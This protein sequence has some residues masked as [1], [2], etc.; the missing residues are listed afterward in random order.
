MTSQASP[1]P[2]HHPQQPH[3]IP[4]NIDVLTPPV[5]QPTQ[6]P[7]TLPPPAA[8]ESA[9][10]TCHTRA[11]P[12]RSTEYH[13]RAYD[14]PSTKDL[15][16][17][18]H[19]TIGSPVKST[20]LHAVQCGNFRSF[21]GLSPENVARYCPTNATPTLLGHLTQV[22][23]GLRSTRWATA[24]H[25]LLT[26]EF[27]DHVLPSTQLI[28]ELTVPTDTLL[29]HEYDISTLFT[30]DLGRFPV[31][32]MSGN[33][34]IMLAYHDA[35]NVI[36][37]QPFQ[38]KGDHH[39]IP[40]YNIIRTRLKSRGINVDQQ[41]LDNEIS[42]AYSNTITEVW[43][44]KLQKV[45]PDMHRR[46]K[47]ERA[48]RTFKA[49]FISILASVDQGFPRNRWDLLLPQAEITVN[50]LRQSSLRPH[51]SAWKHFNGPFNF[52]AT[53]M[54]PPGC[55][56]IAHAKGSTR[57]SW[58]YRGHMGFYVGPAV[59]HY[60][61]YKIIK[62]STSA[63]IVSDTVVFQHP[64]L[65]VP[66]LTTTDRIIHCLRALT[67]AIRADRSKENCHAQLLAV[68]SLRAIFN[69][70]PPPLHTPP[71]R[72]DSNTS[73]ASPA[74]VSVP[75]P[76][77]APRVVEQP[78]RVANVP[79]P[80][81]WQPIAHRTRTNRA[82]AD[83]IALTV[84]PAC[85][86]RSLPTAPARPTYN[87][88]ALLA[89]DDID[90]DDLLPTGTA[91]SVLDRDTGETLE[92]TQLRRHPKYKAKWDKS[93]ANEHGRLCQGA[94]EHPTKPNSQRIEGTNT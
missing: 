56:A 61:C 87:Q 60:R 39:R 12:A 9:T 62:T 23:K 71:I 91:Y 13:R 45:P 67:V 82:N 92:H 43:K 25:A 53:P 10:P 65:S 38:S 47:A 52:D 69:S 88:F 22:P 37:V 70:P 6:A 18:L 85:V 46:N 77:A 8:P 30:D 1:P 66:T 78:P 40:A 44:C 28:H 51:I 63:V 64:T 14:L 5:H 16:D 35:A 24:A 4:D 32:A 68:E 86:T 15:I 48:I 34:Y 17:Y 54:G 50:L 81:P 74:R 36:L 72:A 3:I 73:H 59:D 93:Y 90:G 58:D 75:P 94:G 80:P 19:C 33:Q 42:A 89:D 7:I 11:P 49:H 41:V 76:M 79:D 55:K 83:T 31:R 84:A 57:L 29:I 2:A 21:P 27:G 26:A 20:L